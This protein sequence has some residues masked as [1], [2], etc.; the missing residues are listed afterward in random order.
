MVGNAAGGECAG[1]GQNRPDQKSGCNQ[2]K[3]AY[4]GLLAL[5]IHIFP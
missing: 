3:E 1:D 5:V 4:Q 2:Y